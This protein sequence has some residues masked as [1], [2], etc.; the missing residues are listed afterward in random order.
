VCAQTA[1]SFSANIP[2]KKEDIIAQLKG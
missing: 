2:E 1:D